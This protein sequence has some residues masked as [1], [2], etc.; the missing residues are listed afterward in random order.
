MVSRSRMP[1]PSCT[2]ISSPT[3]SRIALIAAFVDRLA[4]EGAVQV[5]Q[6]QAARAGVT[7]RRAIAAGSSPK[8]VEPVHVALLAGARSG[9][10]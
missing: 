3:A 4:G 6:V 2:G 10:L 9:R 7:Q 1:P 8:V 5:D